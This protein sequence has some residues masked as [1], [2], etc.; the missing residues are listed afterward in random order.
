MLYVWVFAGSV[1]AAGLLLSALLLVRAF[2]QVKQLGRTV[3][4]ASTRIADAT[5]A[6]EAVRPPE[7]A[8]SSERA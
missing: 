4:D 8:A 3:A 2:R 6:M 7:R 5:A 1:F